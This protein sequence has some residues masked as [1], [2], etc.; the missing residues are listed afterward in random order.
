MTPIDF[1]FFNLPEHEREL[2]LVLRGIV[3]DALP[4]AQERLAYRAPFYYGKRRICYI[5]PASIPWGG[6]R[7]GVALGF[8]YGHLLPSAP[9]LEFATRKEVGQIILQTADAIHLPQLQLL[10]SE[11]VA[12]DQQHP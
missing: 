4:E 5:W 6:I 8:C 9:L 11:A 3:R 7:E 1:T 2:A 10:L 12:L